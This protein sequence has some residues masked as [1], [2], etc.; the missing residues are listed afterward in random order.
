MT[1]VS[2]HEIFGIEHLKPIQD[3][4]IQWYIPGQESVEPVR[5]Y[6]GVRYKH[7]DR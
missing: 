1:H 7:P 2:C 6:G 4:I 3:Q 5:L